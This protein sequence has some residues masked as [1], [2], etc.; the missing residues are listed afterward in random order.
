[1]EEVSDQSY[2]LNDQYKNASNLN[3][4]IQLHARFGTN[5][6]DWHRWLFDQFKITHGSRILELGCGTG[7]L[8]VSNLDR[9]PEDW[10]I[11]LSDFS[12]GMLQDAQEKLSN[13]THHFTFEVID[14]QYI[15]FESRSFDVVIANHMLY[16]V[17]D[18]TKALAEIRRVLRPTGRF[19][20]STIGNT[21]MLEIEELIRRVLPAHPNTK[22]SRDAF[23]LESGYEQVAKVFPHVTLYRMENTLIVTEAEP[24]IQ[25]IL[26]GSVKSQ[27]TGEKEQALREIIKQELATHGSIQI[28]TS[29]GVFEAYS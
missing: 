2:L 15:P 7:L 18:R 25:Y 21:H 11:T 10:N 17:P 16:H 9:I 26:S 8:W 4:R 24:L 27:L 6:Y 22:E 14:A 23:S 5:K 29:T 13:S 19:Y 20:A 12:V 1:M 28:G 3:A